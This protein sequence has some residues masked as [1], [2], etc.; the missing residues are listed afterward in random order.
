MDCLVGC[1]WSFIVEVS[2]NLGD[3]DGVNFCGQGMRPRPPWWMGLCLACSGVY[4]AAVV[5]VEMRDQVCSCSS[6]SEGS[7]IVVARSLYASFGISC[8]LCSF[9]SSCG[10]R[11]RCAKLL[12][13]LDISAWRVGKSWVLSDCVCIYVP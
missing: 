3:L 7:E 11:C 8:R 6:C 2:L 5:W 9:D 4:W 13:Y 12:K 10:H 1:D